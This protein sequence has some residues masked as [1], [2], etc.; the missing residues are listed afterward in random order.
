M[1]HYETLRQRLADGEVLVLD[2]AVG[3]QL[4][5]LGVPI[6]VTAWAGAAQH[7]HPDTVRFMHETYIRAGVDIVT[8]NT[9]STARHCLEPI[10][11]GD[12]T[13][14]LNLRAVVLA[15]EA[16]ARAAN[17]RAVYIAGSVSNF[18]IKVGGE[19]LPQRLSDGWTGYHEDQCRA[20]LREQ[21][22]ILAESGVDFLLAE[23]TGNTLHRRWVVEACQASG[24]PVWPGF[25]AHAPDDGALHVGHTSDEPFAEGVDAVL[26]LGGDVMAIFHTPPQTT[27][28][29]LQVLRERWSGPIAVYPDAD[30]RDY[31]AR[32]ADPEQR[33][34]DTPEQFLAQ[35]QRWVEQGVQIVGGCCGFGFD[36]IRPLRNALPERIRSR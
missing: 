25:K 9:Y 10:G 8:T 21:A 23:S 4:Q 36:Y 16:R 33:N 7:T 14:E 18:G 29:C 32:R 17:G 5:A 1:S 26:P 27:T 12:L 28:R 15:Q 20:N 35:A 3:T 19:A 22:S 24:L 11:L 31:V 13:R 6:G 2:G 34:S 30:R